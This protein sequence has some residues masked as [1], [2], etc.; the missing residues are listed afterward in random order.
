M[1][2]LHSPRREERGESFSHLSKKK[3][4][5]GRR[6]AAAEGEERNSIIHWE[7]GLAFYYAVKKKGEGR[8]YREENLALTKASPLQEIF[9]LRKK[10]RKDRPYLAGQVGEG[11]G[12]RVSMPILFR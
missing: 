11:R 10:K 9:Y 12:R 3:R 1:W 5:K 4:E 6:F 8:G 2:I 7:K